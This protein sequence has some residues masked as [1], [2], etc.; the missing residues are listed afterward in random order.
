VTVPYSGA[1]DANFPYNQHVA[2]AATSDLY[3]ADFDGTPATWGDS[4]NSVVS[5][6]EPH[7]ECTTNEIGDGRFDTAFVPDDAIQFTVSGSSGSF[8]FNYTDVHV[9]DEEDTHEYESDTLPANASADDVREALNEMLAPLSTAF[10]TVV[11]V[12]N[13]YTV[14]L[15]DSDGGTGE[16]VK[17]LTASA[18][19]ELSVVRSILPTGGTEAAIGRIDMANLDSAFPLLDEE[20]DPMSSAEI[21]LTLLDRYFDKDHKWRIGEVE[22]EKALI[23]Q[24][25][26]DVTSP[27]HADGLALGYASYVGSGNVVRNEGTWLSEF[28]EEDP[29]SYLFAGLVHFG[30]FDGISSA[31]GF[32]PPAI[33]SYHFN[34]L[35][36]QAVFMSIA[37]SWSRDW[38]NRSLRPF[39]GIDPHDYTDGNGNPIFPTQ[40]G[41]PQ[42]SP[43]QRALLAADGISLVSTWWRGFEVE[44]ANGMFHGSTPLRLGYTA[45]EGFR[46]DIPAYG[47]FTFDALMGDPSVR[48]AYPKPV[49]GIVT[50]TIDLAT[51]NVTIGWDESPEDADPDFVGYKVYRASSPDGEFEEIESTDP[52]DTEFVDIDPNNYVYMVRAIK[53]ENDGTANEYEN[54]STGVFATAVRFS[55]T[56]DEDTVY[57]KRRATDPN[58]IDA[59]AN[60]ALI[61]APNYSFDSRIVTYLE[62]DS[63]AGNDYF[64]LDFT[65]GT[66]VPT[67]TTLILDGGEGD[68]QAFSFCAS[69]DD[70]GTFTEDGATIN[71][72]SIG[73]NDIDRV[74][75]TG[76]VENLASGNGND[77]VHVT[78]GP[79]VRLWSERLT[80]LDIENGAR[81]E[82][83]PAG[84]VTLIVGSL[85]LHTSGTL[86]LNDEDMIVRNTA[87]TSVEAKIAHA[88]N[89]GVSGLW[90]GTGITSSVARADTSNLTTLGVLSGAQYAAYV[91]PDHTFNGFSFAD[92]D[93][94]VKYTYAGDA[95]LTGDVNFDDYQRIDVGFNTGLTGWFNGD[96][97]YSGAVNFDDYVLLDVNFNN[98]GDPL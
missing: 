77:N 49:S 91:H 19:G 17:T 9:E 33:T 92:G 11:K 34:E 60:H 36:A 52:G 93:V 90:T 12:G 45:G 83:T 39:I 68:D 4:L 63:N 73:F 7:Y 84:N 41:Y 51:G 18:S 42:K 89:N 94:L 59:W 38:N 72:L 78:G 74:A 47:N 25:T 10:A 70:A 69:T 31:A 5:G 65:A 1:P 98:P 43:L 22:A 8:Q 20:E 82:V 27:P 46:S 15:L 97:N 3:Y 2:S 61:S 6:N 57:L 35:P 81:A 53:T 24:T 67:T 79:T 87:E 71:G 32:H 28:S 44:G 75:F 40:E 26:E 30:R 88:R 21:E 23:D 50:E 96:F 66:P 37:S 14:R 13:T 86:D 56:D 54:A 62:F 76:N 85:N 55:G 58:T 48:A 64:P 29:S 16:Y 95:Q 80:S